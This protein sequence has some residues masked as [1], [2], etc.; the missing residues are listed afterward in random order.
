MAARVYDLNAASPFQITD[1]LDLHAVVKHSV[2]MCADSRELLENGKVKLAEVSSPVIPGANYN[3][4][5]SSV[6]AE[7]HSIIAI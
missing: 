5:A 3:R 4:I 7:V 1:I 2:P 6:Q